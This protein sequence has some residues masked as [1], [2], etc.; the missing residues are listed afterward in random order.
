MRT[1]AQACIRDAG[2]KGIK[3]ALHGV[4]FSCAVALVLAG[5]SGNDSED[6]SP[7]AQDGSALEGS[8][9]SQSEL[10]PVE[11]VEATPVRDF[12]LNWGGPK[13]IIEGDPLDRKQVR[14]VGQVAR[15]TPDRWF[16]AQHGDTVEYRV[17][18]YGD[19]FPLECDMEPL[20]KCSDVDPRALTLVPGQTVAIEGQYTITPYCELDIRACRLLAVGEPPADAPP[21]PE[22]FPVP[23]WRQ[24]GARLEEFS[25][26]N[27]LPLE[28]VE[29]GGR[30]RI[31]LQ[32]ALFEDASHDLDGVLARILTFPVEGI[33]F[34]GAGASFVLSNVEKFSRLREIECRGPLDCEAAEL[35]SLAKL[36]YLD[37]VTLNDCGN[38]S[39]EFAASLSGA[40]N[41]RT[42]TIE[43]ASFG[44]Q[45]FS[46][47]GVQHIATLQE[48]REVSIDC[49][50]LTGVSLEHLS[51]LG[52]LRSLTLECGGIEDDHI[53]HLTPESLPN[54]RFLILSGS[55]HSGLSDAGIEH[56]VQNKLH[57]GA[58]GLSGT[59]VSDHGLM[60]LRDTQ[61]VERF[62]GLP[63]ETSP[64]TLKALREAKLVR[65]ED[66]NE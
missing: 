40:K 55:N 16:Y 20:I 56:L 66:S 38:F 17:Y 15:V 54:L 19:A 58:L 18:L 27:K 3:M 14:L 30:L 35:R 9:G 25:K 10:P 24:V 2:T 49:R 65:D 64:E 37:S 4:A 26:T 59:S 46:D 60:R 32:P 21:Q 44:E 29:A 23:E 13:G 52:K 31:N 62:S 39:D 34:P 22:P 47:Q 12:V 28:F 41:L 1:M 42:L 48:L 51:R 43:C 36:P 8:S 61:L 33:Q 7:D 6:V 5:C 11:S 57:L 45:H 63:A 50:S 53:R